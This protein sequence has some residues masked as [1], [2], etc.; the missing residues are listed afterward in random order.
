MVERAVYRWAADDMPIAH[1]QFDPFDSPWRPRPPEHRRSGAAPAASAS[2]GS[3]G[4]AAPSPAGVNF[5]SIEDLRAAVDAHE[6]AI[7]AHALGKHRWN[8]RQTA[9]ALG[10][11]YD[12]LRHCI[13][14]HALM[15]GQE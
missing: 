11:T 5:D 3:G 9:R 12:Q 14:K 13:R 10:L 4:L 8:Q 7:L 6:R 2:G 15:E 1:V